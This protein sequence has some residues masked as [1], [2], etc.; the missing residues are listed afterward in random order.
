MSSSSKI[1]DYIDV[2]LAAS[3]PVSPNLASGA[4]GLYFATDT[5]VLS[6][7]TGSSWTALTGTGTV[8]SVG[9]DGTYLTGGPITTSGTV[10]PT[11]LTES[12]VDG[13][14]HRLCGGI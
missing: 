1:T 13:A 2:G 9:T 7:W 6:I 10:S 3:R 12:S 14:Q 4:F 8:T 5:N 11:T